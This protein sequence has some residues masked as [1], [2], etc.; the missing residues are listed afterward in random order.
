M[1]R[2]ITHLRWSNI[3]TVG[4]SPIVRA[5]IVM[6]VVGYLILLNENLMA[7]E[8]KYR[9]FFLHSPWRLVFIYYGFLIISVSAI[10][11]ALQCPNQIRKYSSPVEYM[12]SELEFLASFFRS[13]TLLESVSAR[14][15]GITPRQKRLLDFEAQQGVLNSVSFFRNPGSQSRAELRDT[16]R[17]LITWD[18][19]LADTS[20][21]FWCYI[22]TALYIAGFAFLLI[23]AACTFLDVT[24]YTISQLFSGG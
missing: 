24:R 7:I 4:N 21:V 17:E 23:P 9:Y 6:P 13:K 8:A 5:A 10:M 22:C 14:V 11:Y 3:R 19:G 16:L 12:N 18:W 2:F 15:Y 20:R 1:I